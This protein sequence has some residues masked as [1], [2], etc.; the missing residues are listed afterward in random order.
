MKRIVFK[1]TTKSALF[2]I[3]MFLAS[4]V[5]AQNVNLETNTT[6]QNLYHV[7]DKAELEN[8]Y[9]Q[10]IERAKGSNN[11]MEQIKFGHDLAKVYLYAQE[12]DKAAD[13]LQKNKELLPKIPSDTIELVKNKCLFGKLKLNKGAYSEALSL[14]LEGISI[15][16]NNPKIHAELYKNIAK[17]Y[18]IR[19]EYHLALEYVEKAFRLEKNTYSSVNLHIADSYE[20]IG[21]CYQQLQSYE[22]SNYYYEESL[23]I[24]NMLLVEDHP[25][26][27]D[28]YQHLA[29][30][31]YS[32]NEHS[33]AM[34]YWLK[35][36]KIR[37]KYFP[38][39]HIYM[40]NTYFG[41]AQNFYSLDENE[42]A[43]KYFGK[44]SSI[45]FQQYGH[46]HPKLSLV[47]LEIGNIYKS[48]KNYDQALTFYQKSIASNLLFFNDSLKIE[49]KPVLV[50]Y[51][52]ANTL[53]SALFE[54]T[55]CLEAR[56]EQDNQDIDLKIALQTIQLCDHLAMKIQR[57]HTVLNDKISLA[58]I[59][60]DIY[61]SAISVCR[62]I[63][64][65][66]N[67]DK[68]LLQAFYASEKNKGGT[69]LG[70]LA[71]IEAQKI[72]EVP[73]TTQEALKTIRKNISDYQKT[74]TE[75]P[76][77][78][79]ADEIND[80]LFIENR[81]YDKLIKELETNYLK[82]RKF[83]Y[84]SHTTSI[85]KLQS[86]LDKKTAIRSYFIGKSEIYIFTLTKSKITLESVPKVANFH[87]QISQ[88]RLRILG[89][90]NS[91]IKEYQE[92][93]HNIYQQLFPSKLP[94]KIK[95][96]IIIPDDILGIIP[97][98]ALLTS[99][100]DGAIEQFSSY[101][102]LIKK[103][104]ISYSYSIN[105]FYHTFENQ[106]K[107][108]VNYNKDWLALAPVF[109]D[110]ETSISL[111]NRSFLYNTAND[112]SMRTQTRGTLF[113]GMHVAPLPASEKEVKAILQQFETKNKKAQ[114][115]TH[116]QTTEA[117]VK[118]GALKDYRY[119]H[120][121]THGFVNS[122]KPELSFIL[123]A[124]DTT[125]GNDGI[126]FSGEIYG[127][128]FNADLVVLSACETG[129][130]K[131]SKGEGIIGLSRALL[132]AG[133][134]NIIVSL[135]QVADKSTSDLMVSFYESM[136]ESEK[137]NIN[138][139]NAFRKSKLKMI[140]QNNKYAHPYFWS[141]FILVGK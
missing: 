39:N 86:I 109:N 84:S 139:A 120:F 130:G 91:E 64:E 108:S 93:A 17:T 53:L 57:S 126:L 92:L 16:V 27:A 124:P 106:S 59:V 81:N 133:S 103:Y 135:W 14:F 101:P 117:F 96:L 94:R 44:A 26:I 132:Y 68:Y 33:R 83:K 11:Y 102:Y 63:Y 62:N 19:H 65:L 54:K 138:Y 3:F 105:L 42:R 74:I 89:K 78:A 37:K 125:G 123:L 67:V 60:N 1:I 121:A 32:H 48:G 55:Q 58:G 77:Q 41:V 137:Q 100:Y 71:E 31:Y 7:Y 10:L 136:L 52:E 50:H 112:S 82:Y 8:T 99:S 122:E 34:S 13:L 25:K 116:A 28:S 110:P 51:S 114:I 6:I 140:K 95:N 9:L 66:T 104:N 24:R 115:R 21:H 43:L 61:S 107:I 113:N 97:F 29:L 119:L 20:I 45:Y 15:Q 35:T 73:D 22:L 49:S 18:F 76:N 98:E 87:E 129:L 75:N 56:Y 36:L 40:A 23:K 4:S 128:E 127:L 80:K 47:F 12:N 79:N 70:A 141:P 111:S 118:S 90:K 72:A 30:L 5:L 69:L 38:K 46:K 134:K 131:I 88:L 2:F 85:E